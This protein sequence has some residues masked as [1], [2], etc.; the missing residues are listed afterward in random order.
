ME[1]HSTPEF[2]VTFW[3]YYEPIF[4]TG[5]KQFHGITKPLSHFFL[6]FPYHSFY[7]K[8]KSNLNY[9]YQTEINKGFVAKYF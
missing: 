3:L 7:F 8:A 6:L 9:N 5:L 4:S 2:F 1:S